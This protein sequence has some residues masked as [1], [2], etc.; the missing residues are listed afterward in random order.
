MAEQ[1]SNIQ[2][3]VDEELRNISLQMHRYVT[4]FHWPVGAVLGQKLHH[5]LNRMTGQC[6]NTTGPFWFFFKLTIAALRGSVY[7][8]GCLSFAD[9]AALRETVN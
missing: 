2:V 9:Q 7:E 6:A 4:V 1:V 5:F 3:Q 8:P